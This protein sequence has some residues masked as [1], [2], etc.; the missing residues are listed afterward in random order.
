MSGLIVTHT[1]R[2]I[3]PLDIDPADIDPVDVAH[4]LSNQCRYTGHT[5]PYYSV[6]THSCLV[7]DLLE[8]DGYDTET[9]MWGLLHDAE[10][11]A[12]L[13][14][15]APVK[16]HPSGFGKAFCDASDAISEAVAMRFGLS[17]PVPDIVK[18]IDVALREDEIDQLFKS[19]PFDRN[20]KK[21]LGVKIP[22]WSPS[23]SKRQMLGRMSVY[24]LV[25]VRNGEWVEGG[26]VIA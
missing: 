17:M 16:H 13:D 15:A 3:N 5:D 10:E 6:A 7:H 23:E 20:N 22:A 18:E 21:K 25:T 1:G 9:C 11:Y 12:L 4:A 19:W 26:T 14:L 24:G 2:L 8:E